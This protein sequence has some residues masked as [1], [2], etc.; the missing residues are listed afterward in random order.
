[1]ATTDGRNHPSLQVALNGFSSEKALDQ[2]VVLTTGIVVI[3][4]VKDSL[5]CMELELR[6]WAKR[7]QVSRTESGKQ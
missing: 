7:G 2:L 3:T 4:A 1:M 5:P 6:K